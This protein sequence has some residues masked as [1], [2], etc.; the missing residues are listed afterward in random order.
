MKRRLF[1]YLYLLLL[2]GL[3]SAVGITDQLLQTTALQ[4]Q[5]AQRYYHEMA[6]GQIYHLLRDLQGLPESRWGAQLAAWQPHYGLRL[7]LVARE[8]LSAD[9]RAQLQREDFLVLEDGARFISEVRLGAATLLQLQTPA[10]PEGSLALQIG[11]N[12]LMGALLALLVLLWSRWQWRDLEHLRQ[13]AERFG[14][15]EFTSRARVP[16]HAAV[17]ELA[18]HFNQMASQIEQLIG[19]Q[20]ELLNAVSHELRTPL[21]RLKFELEALRAVPLPAADAAMLEEMGKDLQE[22]EAL[23]AELLSYT[24]L[25]QMPNAVALQEVAAVDWLEQVLGGLAHEAQARQI[26]CHRVPPVPERVAL[27][28]KLMARAASNLLGNALRH[29]RQRVEIRLE[30]PEPQWCRLLVD[31][32]GPGVPPEDVERIFMPFVRLDA[33][34]HRD[35]GGYGLGLAIVQR[36]AEKHRGQ[37]AVTRSPLGGARFILTWPTG[38][39]PAD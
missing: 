36:I 18:S 15:G 8:T 20:K 6:R 13:V 3:V 9:E 28:P 14:R 25:E 11:A 5:V 39:E 27:E 12:L 16:S 34:R 2:I 38:G 24:R 17:H 7:Q 37:I 30:C 23:I 22:M 35:T 10:M 21:S 33:S 4:D 19:S 29:A 32:D 1:F 31:D 26:E